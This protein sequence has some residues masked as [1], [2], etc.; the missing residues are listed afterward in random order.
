M[1]VH[2]DR[3]PAFLESIPNAGHIDVNNSIHITPVV[4]HA[5]IQ[6]PSSPSLDS[7]MAVSLRGGKDMTVYTEGFSLLT[8]SRLYIAETIN[9]VKTTVPANS[10]IPAGADFYP[11]LSLFAPEKRFG[12]SL[13]LVKPLRLSG[14]MGS[15][16]INAGDT[17]NPLELKSADDSSLAEYKID[18]ELNSIR[19]PAELPPINLMNWLVT[20]E[21]IH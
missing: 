11:P 4:G 8:D 15:L 16:K 13:S 12:E 18:A 17:F 9:A 19:S 2:L 20:I 10:G 5:S 21:E 3:L 6:P 14:Q 1:I 7:D